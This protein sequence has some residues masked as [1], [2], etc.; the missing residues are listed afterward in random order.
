VRRRFDSGASPEAPDWRKDLVPTPL[1][2]FF[3]SA[4]PWPGLASTWVR[5]RG[6]TEIELVLRPVS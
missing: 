3:K 2:I 1:D 4:Y 6:K 5:M